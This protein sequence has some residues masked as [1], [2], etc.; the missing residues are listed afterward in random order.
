MNPR[1]N[2]VLLLCLSNLFFGLLPITVKWASRL[3]YSAVQITFFRFAFATLGIFG[4][5]SLGW[6]KLKAVNTKALLLRGFFGGFT[7]LCYF[8]ALHWTTVAKGTLLNYTYS[9]WANLFSVLFLRQKAPRGLA[10]LLLLAA[11]GVWLVLD[12]HFDHLNGGDIAGFLSGMLG[13]AGVLST[14]EARRTDNALSVFGSF[15]FFGLGI[16]AILLTQLGGREGTA[17]AHWTPVDGKGLGILCLM[18]GIGHGGPASLYPRPG[19][20]QPGHGDPP[21]PIG[22]GPCGFL[23][24]DHPRRTFD[25]PLCFRNGLRP[26]GLRP[27]GLPGKPGPASAG[28][29]PSIDFFTSLRFVFTCHRNRPTQPQILPMGRKPCP[30]FWTK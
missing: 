27:A 3:D 18:G 22:S 15:T 13:G 29:I 20:C 1:K 26:D 14:K 4:L 9:L 6:Q 25:A 23:R 7:V 21:G 2:G 10:L 11:G 5:A 19:T 28:I 16:S 12:A 24:M 8:L 17:L 30:K